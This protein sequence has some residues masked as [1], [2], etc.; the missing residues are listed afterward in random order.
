MTSP[1]ITTW[2]LQELTKKKNGIKHLG[3][4]FYSKLTS[5]SHINAVIAGSH[6]L[7]GAVI[8]YGAITWAHNNIKSEKRLTRTALN[9]PYQ[10]NNVNHIDLLQRMKMMN[11]LRIL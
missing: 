1:H 8:E 4:I 5:T 6:V 11:L 3:V 7:Y 2:A 9:A 10:H